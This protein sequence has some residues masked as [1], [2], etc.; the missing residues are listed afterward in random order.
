MRRIPSLLVMLALAAS[1]TATHAA[2]G[3]EL[4][5]VVNA[6]NPIQVQPPRS[7]GDDKDILAMVK[8]NPRA[9]GYLRTAPADAS[10]RVVLVLADAAE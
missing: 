2:P 9:I 10:V 8:S 6:R 5:M 1:A 7:L 4:Y 3:N